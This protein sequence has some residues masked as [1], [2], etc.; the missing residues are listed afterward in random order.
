MSKLAL[1]CIAVVLLLIALASSTVVVTPPQSREE[2]AI[3]WI[4]RTLNRLGEPALASRLWQDFRNGRIRFVESKDLDHDN[5]QISQDSKGN[6]MELNDFM[7]NIAEQETLLSKNPYGA[8][9]INLVIAA[10]TVV[11]EYVHMG[12]TRPSLTAKFEDPAWQYSDKNYR[13]WFIRLR[14][15]LEAA[16]KLPV[17]A[18]RTAKVREILD[19]LN[20]LSDAAGG[21]AAELPKKT[22]LTPG[23][24]WYLLSGLPDQIRKAASDGEAWLA[25]ADKVA[26]TTASQ[27]IPKTGAWVLATV[28]PFAPEPR[29]DYDHLGFKFT[30]SEGIATASWYRHD[31]ES[32]RTNLRMTWTK[33]PKI[34]EPGKAF[35]VTFTPSNNG[36]SAGASGF[37]FAESAVY[38]SSK[39]NDWQFLSK[40]KSAYAELGQPMVP[41][42]VSFT[43]PTGSPGLQ[44]AL[45]ITT[46]SSL[47]GGWGY[48]YVYEFK[49]GN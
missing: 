11:H 27:T 40:G 1:F 15:E 33:P 47:I 25:K 21:D 30:I 6:Y 37:L 7:L 14:D 19:L 45:N 10:S 35:S 41:T 26:G 17:S 38:S 5:A 31:D 12:Q 8:R 46:G 39:P 2:I 49:R 34:I 48:S 16:K 44:Y 24:S 42:T 4:S 29:S 23:Q 20:R 28:S 32:I 3:K 9:N 43:A 36:S 13:R 18:E 22:Y